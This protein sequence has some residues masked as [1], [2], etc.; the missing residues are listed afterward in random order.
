MNRHPMGGCFSSHPGKLNT[1]HAI[2]KWAQHYAKQGVHFNDTHS[3]ALA[4]LMPLLLCGEQSA[5]LV[6]QQ[7]AKVLAPQVC[8]SSINALNEVEADEAWHDEALQWVFAQLPVLTEQHQ[9]RRAAQRFYSGL[10]RSESLQQQFIRIASLD[11]CVTQLMQ[12]MER[13]TIGSQHPFSLLCGLIKKDEAKHVYVSK[14]FAK[15]LGAS[16]ADIAEER[17]LILQQLMTLLGRQANQFEVLGVDLEVL[18]KKLE[19]KWL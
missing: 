17:L 12:M 18:Q 11:A 2:A 19:L 14:Y 6:F 10:G 5:Q 4:L 9:I 7:Q 1:E 16:V 8:K 3:E 13:G 15:H